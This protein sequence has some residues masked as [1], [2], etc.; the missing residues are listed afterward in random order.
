MNEKNEAPNWSHAGITNKQTNK[1]TGRQT[2]TKKQHVHKYM[3]APC[4]LPV[5]AI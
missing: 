1:Q 3:N 2:E 5:T 4:Q